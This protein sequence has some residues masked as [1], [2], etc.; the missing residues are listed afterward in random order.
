MLA[1]PHVRARLSVV[2]GENR[3]VA[4]IEFAFALPI[5]TILFVGGY[6]LSD[7]ISASRKVT[8]ATRT[9]TDLTSQYTAVTNNDLDTIL[10]ASQ[11]VM[12]PYKASAA[13]MTVTQVSID[14][15]G[16]AKVDWSRGKN[17][18]GLTPGISF[19]LPA[20]IKQPNTSLIVAQ[21][22]YT[23]T[24][25]IAPSMIGTIP[26]KEQIIMS[27]RATASIGYSAT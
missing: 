23:Y 19:S 10:N 22:I 8:R 15:T 2:I 26:L 13:T 5:L 17:S 25:I 1:F 12:S 24:P 6:Q 18:A 3:G 27:P 4:I 14:G 21:I 11:Q 20:A 7:A 9:I 16:N